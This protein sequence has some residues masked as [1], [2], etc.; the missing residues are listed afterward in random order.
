VFIDPDG[1]FRMLG[2][3][4]EVRD[5]GNRIVAVEVG[6]D[7]G[8]ASS[9][10]VFDEPVRAL[11]TAAAALGFRGNGV[12]D[13]LLGSNGRPLVIEM[14]PRRGTATFVYGLAEALFGS[15]W[16]EWISGLVRVPLSIEPG[17]SIEP[18][19]ALEIV[20]LTNKELA[21]ESLIVPLSLTWLKSPKPGVA[22]ATFAR[23]RAE[24]ARAEALF[25][26]SLARG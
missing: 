6:K 1:G 5:A 2:A 14:N 11:C 7:S 17:R 8:P 15:G 25:S 19:R 21:G 4:R 10:S 22:I 26:R 24:I 18:E 3:A 20:E 9:A 23:N 12:F 13:F 16:P